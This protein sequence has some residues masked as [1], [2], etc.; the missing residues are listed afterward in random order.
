MYSFFKQIFIVVMKIVIGLILQINREEVSIKD[1]E[2]GQEQ[3]IL[4]F[5]YN[6]LN[7]LKGKAII[8]LRLYKYI[9]ISYKVRKCLVEN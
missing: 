7:V 2:K 1:R 3:S 9:S 6:V 8:F 5:E 4:I